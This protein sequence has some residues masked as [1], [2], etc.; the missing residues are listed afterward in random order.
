[1]LTLVHQSIENIHCLHPD[2]P[3]SKQLTV[4]CGVSLLDKP[5]SW[6]QVK[7]AIEYIK[8]A[9][10]ALYESKYKGRNCDTIKRFGFK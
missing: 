7:P 4:S 3:I 2:S 8:L 6:M 5:G 1:M 10:K 9:D